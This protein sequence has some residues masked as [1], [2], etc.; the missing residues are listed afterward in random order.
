MIASLGHSER[1]IRRMDAGLARADREVSESTVRD[2]FEIG[3]FFSRPFSPCSRDKADSSTPPPMAANSEGDQH[4]RYP[5]LEERTRTIG[6][7]TGI[8]PS[9]EPSFEGLPET[10]RATLLAAA[11]GTRPRGQAE[12]RLMQAITALAFLRGCSVASVI[13]RIDCATTTE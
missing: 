13:S 4:V 11:K 12:R 5:L 7:T 1:I 8:G 3:E 10:E 9:M 6:S 2:V